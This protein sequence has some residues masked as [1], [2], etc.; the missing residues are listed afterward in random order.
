MKIA[1]LGLMRRKCSS[2]FSVASFSAR[3]GEGSHDEQPAPEKPL[4]Q[5]KAAAGVESCEP[6]GP[7]DHAHFAESKSSLHKVVEMFDRVQK[8]T[9][10][11]SEYQQ[12]PQKPLSFA[13]MLRRSKLI[14]IGSA[15]GRHVVGTVV[16][17]LDDDLYIDF[18][19]KFHCVCKKPK[20]KPRYL[21]VD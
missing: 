9:E 4:P 8:D 7:N 2:V 5:T 13:T 19:G 3:R 14:E 18:G 1:V 12:P 21:Q 17:V 6:I 20:T 10:K 11:K 15:E 16:E